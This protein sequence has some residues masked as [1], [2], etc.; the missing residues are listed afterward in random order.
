[1][2]IAP[3]SL[4]F[5]N[6]FGMISLSSAAKASGSRKELGDADQQIAEQQIELVRLVAQAFDVFGHIV[7][8]QYLHAPLD[9]PHQGVLFVLAEIVAE[10]GPQQC[11]NPR[12]M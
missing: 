12:Q 6:N 11:A 3:P 7:D 8:L 4:F 2:R 10:P 9:A 5:S 1:M